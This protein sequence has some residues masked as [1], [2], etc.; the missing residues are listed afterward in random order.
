M[1]SYH[2]DIDVCYFTIVKVRYRSK[3]YI[4]AHIRT[5]TKYSNRLIGEERNVKIPM[6][7]FKFLKVWDTNTKL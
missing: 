2:V 1:I 3:D 7:N 5:F 4:K 6:K